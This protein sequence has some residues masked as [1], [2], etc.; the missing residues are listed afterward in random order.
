MKRTMHSISEPTYTI[1][2]ENKGKI[3]RRIIKEIKHL[4]KMKNVV[5]VEINEKIRIDKDSLME[6]FFD[7][8]GN[9]K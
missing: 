2:Q 1:W 8:K 7:K 9:P 4:P 5:M 6:R 3:N